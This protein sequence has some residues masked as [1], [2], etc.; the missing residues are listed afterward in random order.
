MAPELYLKDA[1]NGAPQD[2]WA[3]GVLLFVLVLNDL[4]FDQEHEA[5]AKRQFNID[6]RGDE[7]KPISFLY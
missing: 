4:P 6:P 7:G 1:V 2:V 3:L 5:V